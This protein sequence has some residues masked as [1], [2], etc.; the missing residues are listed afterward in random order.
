MFFSFVEL[1]RPLSKKI[2]EVPALG[3]K[4]STDLFSF[5]NS[6]LRKR[7][8]HFIHFTDGETCSNEATQ[9]ESSKDRNISLSVSKVVFAMYCPEKEWR[10]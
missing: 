5:H 9:P 10:R 1:Q 3:M 4:G 6:S 7:H 2:F 8:L